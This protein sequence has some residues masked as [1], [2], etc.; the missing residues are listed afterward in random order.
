MEAFLAEYATP[1]VIWFTGAIVLF[2][3]ELGLPGFVIFY[4]GVGA[5]VV[6]FTL[7][8]VGS[9]SLT[10][11]LTI[12]FAVTLVGLLT[13]RKIL[14]AKFF[15]K[16]DKEIKTMDHEFDGYIAI[17]ISTVLQGKTGRVRFSGT[18][19]DALFTTDVVEGD[20]VVITGKDGNFLQ[21]KKQSEDN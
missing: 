10:T 6:F 21:V 9:I 17:A 19:W 2:L 3:L 13:T 14:V 16:S 12:W 5:L 7:K 20:E 15:N 8:L 4:F 1:A 11:Q 18:E